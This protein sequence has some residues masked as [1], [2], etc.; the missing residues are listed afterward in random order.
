MRSHKQIWGDI[1]FSFC[2]WLFLAVVLA[3]LPIAVNGVSAVI[4]DEGDF[5]FESMYERGELLLVSAAVLGAA[6]TELIS[7]DNR[8]LPT[9]RLFVG[10]VAGA[11]A[12]AAS[13]WFADISA[14][15]RDKESLD[16]D[17]IV[18]WST[19]VSMGAIVS[20]VSCLVVAGYSR[21]AP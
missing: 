20:S 9:L 10:L 1:V 7:R 18:V 5:Q 16:V 19:Y 11:I 6:V 2:K 21:E 4:R 3:L 8:R 13:M 14:G 12:F 17:R 15:L